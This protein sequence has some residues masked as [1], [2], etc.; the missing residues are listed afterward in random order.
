MNTET[1]I[2]TE[3]VAEATLPITMEEAKRTYLAHPIAKGV[4]TELELQLKCA[5]N[6]D[7]K[8]LI[9]AGPPGVGKTTLA[10]LLHNKVMKAEMAEMQLDPTYLPIVVVGVD[11]SPER[12]SKWKSL[13]GNILEAFGDVLI[14]EKEG[15]K[16]TGRPEGRISEKA[17]TNRLR[18]VVENQIRLRRVKYLVI[19][20]CQHVLVEGRFSAKR[21]LNMLKSLCTKLGI[22]LV[23]I[24][25]YELAKLINLDG[26][27]IRRCGYI[28][29]RAYNATKQ[30][31]SQFLATVAKIKEKLPL[32]VDPIPDDFMI[33]STLRS[34]GLAKEL[35]L[36]ATQRA[37]SLG[38]PTVTLEDVELSAISPE[39]LDIIFEDQ[40]VGEA[41]FRP[42]QASVDKL[43]EKLGLP[44][45]NQVPAKRRSSKVTPG[46][47]KAK[48]APLGYGA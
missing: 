1:T 30:E 24:G 9:V 29:F 47:L 13:F 45:I 16:Q 34:V 41:L 4:Y 8:M 27:L 7:R 21:N 23:L 43:R 2:T 5:E 42:T 10:T 17:S 15:A 11:E 33:M 20:E 31:T 14:D 6:V 28:H 39:K 36:T 35:L 32:K 26:Q 22:K 38:K 44:P 40:K 18:R 37:L 19:D 46:T 48:H 3:T 25:P 12:K